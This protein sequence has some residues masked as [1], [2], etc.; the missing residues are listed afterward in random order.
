[1][2]KTVVE[3]NKWLSTGSSPIRPAA[4]M[5]IP[6]WRHFRDT[7]RIKAMIEEAGAVLWGRLPAWRKRI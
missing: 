1:M 3:M 5:S 4:L 7:D 6:T 2:G